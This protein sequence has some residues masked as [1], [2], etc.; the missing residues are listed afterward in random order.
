[1]AA[2]DP[3]D[4]FDLDRFVQA[5]EGVYAQA[6]EEL[7]A[8]RKDSHWMWFIFPQVAGLG[9]SPMAQAF[10]IGSQKEGEAYLAHPLLG[11]RLRQCTAAVLAHVDANAE[12]IFGAIDAMKLRSS[13]T[14]FGALAGPASPFALCLQR[15]FNG[16]ADPA[17]LAFLETN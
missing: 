4:P 5:Q 2:A 15:F 6:L 10:A 1:M 3:P 17:T 14:L 8:G 9:R 7:R 16:E 11:P 13:M 12:Q